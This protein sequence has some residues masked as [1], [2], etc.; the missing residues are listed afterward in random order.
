MSS[1][2]PVGPA[3]GSSFQGYSEIRQ[4]ESVIGGIRYQVHVLQHD[5]PDLGICRRLA[6]G[7]GLAILTA[8]TAGLALCSRRVR[9]RWQ[10][11]IAGKSV[12]YVQ[13]P[14]EVDQRVSSAIGRQG[15]ASGRAELGAWMR[16]E[17]DLLPGRQRRI[18]EAYWNKYISNRSREDH[19]P[20]I[21]VLQSVPDSPSRLDQQFAEAIRLNDLRK[22][23]SLFEHLPTEYLYSINLAEG[24]D[25]MPPIPLVDRPVRVT[26]AF[27][28][29]VADYMRD[30]G[31][32]GIV[33]ISDGHATHSIASSNIRDA[34]VPFVIHS[35]VKMFT[36]VLLLRLVE[37]GI[38]NEE[39]LNEPI[40]FQLGEDVIQALSPAVQ[41]QLART[42]LRDVMLHR[43]RY[44]D[45]MKKYE[46]AI[47]QAVAEG[48]PVPEI[49][50]P[51]DLLAYADEELVEL[52]P[53]GS[54][55]SNLGMLLLGLAIEHMYR[56][57]TRRDLTYQE[58]L[59]QHLLRD[60]GIQIFEAEMPR[61]ARVSQNDPIAP[62]VMGSPAGGYWCTANDLL[63]F[64]DWLRQ[65][66][67]RASFMRLVEGYGGEF[68]IERY[69]EFMHGGDTLSSSVHFSH[70]IDNELTVVAMVEMR[71]FGQAT[72]LAQD[73]YDH[74]LG[75]RE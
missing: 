42:T 28:R 58:I 69:R 20:I 2:H 40:Q 54:A 65:Q 39:A 70:R 75:E 59:Q 61:G 16:Q 55:Y 17:R 37:T 9:D 30:K 60:T 64:G 74:L 12:K 27:M 62:H 68:Y 18:A 71:G 41:N 46:N 43:G 49:R 5:Q 34:Q 50:R 63:R 8:V 51:Q 4:T 6:E 44:G 1:S 73:I 67:R 25:A 47:G 35:I 33:A 11:T 10:E 24:L 13:T 3:K 31:I 19:A 26:D 32:S 36:G 38:I 66:C 21:E 14:G 57:S 7:F 48:R 23:C 72:Y 53:D 15:S 29:D 56:E 45:Y 52:G 22:F